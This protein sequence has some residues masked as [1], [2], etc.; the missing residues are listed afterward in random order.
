MTSF[1]MP[2]VKLFIL[3]ALV[4]TLSTKADALSLN[5]ILKDGGVPREFELALDEVQVVGVS[6]R[7]EQVRTAVFQDVQGIRNYAAERR[8]KTGADMRL[9]LY[10]KGKGKSDFTR[11]VL[12]GDI[13]VR[14]ADPGQIGRIAQGKKVKIG[15]PRDYAP[16]YAVIKADD[17]LQT[18]ELAD[19]L[20]A[21]AGVL[22]AEPLLARQ[23]QKKFLPN[24]TLINDQW[25]L[26]N[27]GQ[28]G[29]TAGIDVNITNVWDSYRGDG[30]LIGI[31]DDGLQVTHPDLSPNVN[32]VIDWDWNGDDADP[33]PNLT[34]DH[35]GTACAGVAAAKGNNSLGVSGAA[36]DAT[37]VGMRLISDYTTDSQEAD[38]MAHS[39]G[40][41][42]IKSNSWGP[43]DDGATLEGPGTL[44]IAAL[45]NGVHSGRSGRGV[46][47]TWAG[48]NGLEAYDNGNYDGY[49]N[50]I[51]TVSIAALADD[52]TQ[53]WYSEPGACH[54]VTSPSSGGAQGITTTDLIGGNGY[55][56]GDY[57]DDFG[58]T[59]SATPLAAGVVALMLEANPLLGWRDVQEILIRSAT[60][61]NTGDSDWIN[62]GA[63]YHF[64]HK[65]GAGLINAEAA[66]AMALAWTNLSARTSVSALQ[67]G[68]SI[69][70]PD[71]NATGVTRTFDMSSAGLRVEHVTVKA[72]I[73]HPY[74]GDLEIILTS[75]DGTESVLAEEHGDG[76]ANYSGWTFSSVRHW[77]ENSWGTWTVKVADRAA[78]DVG[79]LS[80]LE[81]TLYGVGA[82]AT[83]LPPA[84]VVPGNQ[85]VTVTNLL[86][87]DVSASEPDGDDITLWATNLPS[88]AAFTTV[89]NAGGVTNTFSWMPSTNQA[90]S[91]QVNFLA[92][93]KD[94]TNNRT[95]SISVLAGGSLDV[96]GYQ[97]L[98]FNSDQT[99]TIPAST[100]IPAG[101]Y[102]VIARN[103]SQA[104]F[105][106]FWGVSFGADVVF[107]NSGDILPQINGAEKYE[108]RDDG[109]MTI[110]G[111][112]GQAAAKNYTVQRIDASLDASQQ[113][114]WNLVPNTS[115]SPGSG[116]TGNGASGLVVSE[117]ADASG[118]G[119]YI[120]EFVELYYD[121][122]GST[123]E[124]PPIL[125]S[126]GNKSSTV[127]GDIQFS[128]SAIPT[129]GD[130]VTLSVSNAP[131]GST[132]GATNETGSFTW[133]TASPAGDYDVTFYASDDD[134]ADSE[135]ITISITSGGSECGLFISEYVDYDG[136]NNKYI[137]LYN[138]SGVS[139]GLGDYDLAIYANGATS[140]GT[141]VALSSA[142]LTNGGVYVL[143]HS[144]ADQWTG[145]PDQTGNLAYNG[146][147][148]IALRTDG[149]A[150]LV[151]VIGRIGEDPG[152]SW[153]SGSYSTADNVLRRNFSV[154]SG[155]PV[156]N[157]AFDPSLEWTSPG[158]TV[159]DGLGSHSSDTCSGSSTG[160]PPN[161]SGLA[162]QNAIVSN[163]LSF[164]VSA[165]QPDVEV[166]TLSASNLPP[167]A[168]FP[169][170]SET[171]TVNG[172]FTFTPAAGQTGQTYTVHFYAADSDGVS[173]GSVQITVL[174]ENFA[175]ST[176]LVFYDFQD[177]S[178]VFEQTPEYATNHITATTFDSYDSLAAFLK[179]NPGQAI[180]HTNWNVSD[181]SRYFEFSITIES[182]YELTLERISFDDRSDAGP[183]MWIVRSSEDSFAGDLGVGSTHSSYE[184][185]STTQQLFGLTG[186]VT[187]RIYGQDAS[188]AAGFWRVDN[189][190]LRGYVTE[191]A[192]PADDDNDGIPDFWENLHFGSPTGMVASADS[193]S[194]GF[195][196]FEEYLADTNPSNIL[197]YLR[198]DALVIGSDNHIQFPAST[199]RVYA[200][201]YKDH[202][203][204]GP[205][206]SNLTGSVTGTNATMSILDTNDV[207]SRNYRIRAQL[208]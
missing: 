62:N 33:S 102:V 160:S 165:T 39:N 186:D 68:L 112:T 30:I 154:T 98:Q 3:G 147:D 195:T 173:T 178:D 79:T 84:L 66:V 156:G 106:S 73:T 95:V 193:D 177:G 87:F 145:T 124:S 114:S 29:G 109:G 141:V 191:L 120:Y 152:T 69:S 207:P 137:E 153:G 71:D 194:D 208:P 143:A 151:D 180:A 108:L 188:D 51:Y 38:A 103:A 26:R 25:H 127:G 144:L 204:S 135:T 110:E 34:Y 93:D 19:E 63:G 37:L 24:D 163:E 128:I 101:G 122:G 14:M 133:N 159:L 53:A 166:V 148:A 96:G 52:G 183:E 92:A 185:N 44:T 139:V 167:N 111:P 15:K 78:S 161:I 190:L 2:P 31:V 6:G 90:G 16:G 129:D 169:Q 18:F 130:A 126:I 56:S 125:N 201:Q 198:I 45:S 202:L 149:G 100:E 61:N 107:L 140:P 81:L 104:A 40:V 119:N 83:N 116:A 41:I 179:G 67:S 48:G 118:G 43:S 196:N 35:H 175:A 197:S 1:R 94:G 162:N 9:V 10:E 192:G 115:A 47:Y 187:F 74:R 99:Y 55:Q 60:K 150:T 117:Y 82:A 75:P 176:N 57:T 121:G 168:S 32:T 50:S 146:D 155:D 172:T 88:G 205:E 189:M 171:G 158:S 91:Y 80:S 21:A 157:D 49:A 76:G 11:R 132:F 65:Y 13:L 5:H 58:G 46:I 164:A 134:G 89:T 22:S 12:T 184:G 23:Q 7:H 86:T 77:G 181:Y 27:Y 85:S 42:H 36:Y 4:C 28:N 97:V 113:S 54:V 20:G 72:S 203:I 174:P 131:A 105:E 17:P 200:L 142:S 70:I 206:W 123:P 136:G 182:G 64:N 199:A 59:S 170:V 138:N 8:T